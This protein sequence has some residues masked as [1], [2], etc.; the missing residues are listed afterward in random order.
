VKSINAGPTSVA[1][2]ASHSSFQLYKTGIYYEPACS[3]TALDHGVTAVGY[4]V[5][6]KKDYYIVK[7]SWDTVWGELGY[8]NMSRNRNNNCGIATMA[9]LPKE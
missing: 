6:G 7:N 1:I 2:D 5:E 4:G 3:P 8:I 9:S